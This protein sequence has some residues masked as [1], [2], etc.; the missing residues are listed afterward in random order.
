MKRKGSA[1]AATLFALT[2]TFSALAGTP[3]TNEPLK[4]L[5][6]KVNLDS[7]EVALGKL[8]YF[9]KRLSGDNTISCATCHDLQK[10]GTDQLPVSIGIHGQ[11]GPINAPTVYNSGYNFRQF[12]DGRAKDLEEQAEGPVANPKEMGATWPDVIKKL[13]SDPMLVADFKKVFEGDISKQTVVKAIATYERTL[14]TPS[15]FDDYLRGDSKAITPEEKHGYA[16]FKSY[17]CAACHNGINV[18]GSMYQKFGLLKN[19]FAE[20]GKVT[21]ADLGRYNVTKKEADKYFFKVPT[22]R[23]VALTAPYLSNGSV[24]SL[25]KT[26]Q[27]MGEYQLGR[28]INDKDAKA[29]VTF[30]KSLT[31][32]SLEKK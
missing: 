25:E 18:G 16:L 11:H 2:Y 30:L 3:L 6:Q 22:L 10:G 12:W 1:L 24:K 27:I 7:R 15:R 32:K 26:V 5:P 19:Y 14:I 31:G 28:Q 13:K 21:E 17:G 4:P 8:L 20:H 29:I 23:N 9:D